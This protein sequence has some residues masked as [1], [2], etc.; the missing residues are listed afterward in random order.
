MAWHV[1]S[2]RMHRRKAA[3]AAEQHVL[4]ALASYHTELVC[5]Q[6]EGQKAVSAYEYAL[7]CG[8]PY[9]TFQRRLKGGEGR[10][11]AAAAQ[12]WLNQA[13]NDTLIEFLL[14]MSDCGFPL[15]RDGAAE[16]ALEI[17]Q[18]R[19]PDLQSLSKNW[20]DGFLIGPSQFK[21][22]YKS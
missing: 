11:A 6:Q 7:E 4:Q 10:N 18:I 20:I 19:H 2:L 13:E 22:E 17:A 12:S 8:V 5:A 9:T 1:D 21:M 14:L 16:Y 15:T 3:E